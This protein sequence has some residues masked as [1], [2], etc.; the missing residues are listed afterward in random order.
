MTE[1]QLFFLTVMHCLFY[2]KKKKIFVFQNSISNL[3]T[4]LMTVLVKEYLL[5]NL[6]CSLRGLTSEH[7]TIFERHQKMV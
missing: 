1:T 3:N 4:M 6:G 2:L 7:F 5:Y